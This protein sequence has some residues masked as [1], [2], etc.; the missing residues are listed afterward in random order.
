MTGFDLLVLAFFAL[1]TLGGFVRGGAREVIDFLA[2]FGS[3]LLAA[4]LGPVASPLARRMIEPD[5]F[6]IGAA[7]VA[8][9]VVFYVAIRLI[10][11]WVGQKM[12]DV[13][14]LQRVDRWA[15]LLIGFV[16]AMLVLGVFHLAFHAIT[17]PER[18][19]GWYKDGAAYPVGVFAA[20][21][22]QAILPGG[23][24]ARPD[25]AGASTKGS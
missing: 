4:I 9:F 25:A 11:V 10:G 7:Y 22:I 20:K 24:K 14:V 1:S 13:D 18:I 6:A 21:A 5:F 2:L 3:I 12:K 15:G 19:P 17:P 16:R 8:V 23:A